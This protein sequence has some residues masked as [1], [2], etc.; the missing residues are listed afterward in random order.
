M[1]DIKVESIVKIS[2]NDDGLWK[3]KYI[4]E[5]NLCTLKQVGGRCYRTAKA[6]WLILKEV[7]MADSL[8]IRKCCVCG[9]LLAVHE[10]IEIKK[11]VWFCEDSQCKIEYEKQGKK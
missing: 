11:N 2:D 7:K 5:G 1:V 10:G 3:V 8:N 4:T 6:D 9:Q